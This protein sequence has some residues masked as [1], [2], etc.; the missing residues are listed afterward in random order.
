VGPGVLLGVPAPEPEAPELGLLLELPGLVAAPGLVLGLEGLDGATDFDDDEPDD[1]PEGLSA[2][3]SH[4]ASA[5]A[6]ATA[7]A[8]VRYRGFNMVMP[9]WLSNW[10]DIPRSNL[11]RRWSDHIRRRQTTDQDC[12]GYREH[13]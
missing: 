11:F 6:A 3:R 13:E 1:D 8:R 2:P 7:A 10:R 12:C 5:K 9:P 4:A